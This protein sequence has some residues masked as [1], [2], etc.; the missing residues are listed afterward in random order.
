ML[1]E[2]VMVDLK[3]ACRWLLQVL[4]NPVWT[5]DE[6]ARLQELVGD[7]PRPLLHAEFRSYARRHGLPVRTK[8]AIDI[9]VH[10]LGLSFRTTGTWLSPSDIG[11]IL[12][13]DPTI[14]MRWVRVHDDL[15]AR[16]FG[17]RLY[18][19]RSDFRR[20]ASKPQH[21]RALG[22]IDV[23]RLAM[24]LEDRELAEQILQRYPTRGTHVRVR[25]R[26]TGRRYPSISAAA[27]DNYLTFS[28]IWHALHE[29]RP[30]GGLSW[31]V[32]R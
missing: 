30:A 1:Q 15:L 25:C 6:D 14:P 27:R 12:G 7:L 8:K 32:L 28:A 23:D 4:T 10:K 2:A 18:V 29:N 21:Q 24:A 3:T 5:Q 13:I 9:R 22:G 20:W 31:E 16:R 19:K 11:C 17:S 26:E